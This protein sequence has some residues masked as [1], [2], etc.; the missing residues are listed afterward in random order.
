MPEYKWSH[1]GEWLTEKINDFK[2]E[3]K[4]APRPR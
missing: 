3:R 2:S 4:E 1:P